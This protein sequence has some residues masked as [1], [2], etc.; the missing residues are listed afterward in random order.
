MPLRQV[1]NLDTPWQRY[2][3]LIAVMVWMDI[4]G[5]VT[6][7]KASRLLPTYRRLLDQRPMMTIKPHLQMANVMG[8]DNTTVC[9]VSFA[10]LEVL[11]R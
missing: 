9:P 3:P 5:S 6:Q 1:Y 10:S 8:C 2:K 4:L 11:A 7:N